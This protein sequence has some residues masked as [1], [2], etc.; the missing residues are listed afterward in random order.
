MKKVIVKT[1]ETGITLIVLV[2]TIVILLILSTISV[3]IFLGDKGIFERTKKA[4]NE[5]EKS[6]E[7]E[8]VSLDKIRNEMNIL[9]KEVEKCVIT[10]YIDRDVINEEEIIKGIDCLKPNTFKPEKEDWEFVGWKEDS[11]AQEEILTEK[12]ADDDIKL[13]AVFKQKIELSYNANKGNITPETQIGYRYY[14]NGNIVNPSFKISEAITRTGY[15]FRNWRINSITGTAYNAGGNITLSSNATMY[16]NWSINSKIIYNNGVE[17]VSM[18]ISGYTSGWE[19]TGGSAKAGNCIVIN[20][21]NW[22]AYAIGTSGKVDLTDF[23]YLKA[24]VQAYTGSLFTMTI[25]ISNLNGLYYLS[26]CGIRYEE[27]YRFYFSVTNS[28]ANVYNS[29]LRH[30]EANTGIKTMTG[31]LHKMWLE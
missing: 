17:N 10:Y 14:N 28:K 9:N 30:A 27:T 15:T 26:M 21:D 18:D 3:R 22:G 5:Y 25:N 1:K 12:L 2:V 7:N 19:I 23:T 8:K 6:I 16:A 31:Y 11:E 24:N 13:Y 20:A 29:N 4:V